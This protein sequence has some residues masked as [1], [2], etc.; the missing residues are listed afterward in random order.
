MP[1]KG[2]KTMIVDDDHM[3]IF[4]AKKMLESAEFVKDPLT[5]A[6]GKTALEYLEQN[7][8]DAE[9]FVIFLD[10]NMPVF[11]GWD[12][13]DRVCEMPLK[14][15]ISVFMVTSSVNVSDKRR[16]ATY[17]VMKAFLEKPVG[18]EKYASLKEMEELR[19]F[20]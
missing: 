15:R 16:A 19:R 17:P 8:D 3:F 14:D 20:F 2:L 1:E 12:F 9:H 10:I 13:L 7:P 6:N 18:K 11:S 4:I 5:Y